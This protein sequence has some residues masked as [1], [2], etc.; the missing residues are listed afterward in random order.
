MTMLFLLSTAFISGF[1]TFGAPP[2]APVAPVASLHQ[3]PD[4][5][6]D[7]LF[8]DGDDEETMGE[9]VRQACKRIG[10]RGVHAADSA[11]GMIFDDSMIA[12]RSMARAADNGKVDALYVTWMI[13]LVPTAHAEDPRL[14]AIVRTL[15]DDYAVGQVSMHVDEDLLLLT[16]SRHLS[17]QD[18]L[19]DAFLYDWLV[20]FEGAC[21]WL[22]Q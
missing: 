3:L 15:N 7:G 22:I 16:I 14:T 13:R 8:Y 20:E 1:L 17:F 12:V 21:D 11:S 6:E 18:R 4:Q 9:L 5:P 19:S 10:A 2:R